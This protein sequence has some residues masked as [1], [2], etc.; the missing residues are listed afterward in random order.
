MFLSAPYT[1]QKFL[2][3]AHFNLSMSYTSCATGFELRFTTA[4]MPTFYRSGYDPRLTEEKLEPFLFYDPPKLVHSCQ[5]K[6]VK[7][8]GES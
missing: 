1:H 7:I 6:P 4:V 5:A 8:Q 3:T 2:Y